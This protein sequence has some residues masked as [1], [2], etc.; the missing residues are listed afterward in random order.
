MRIW[1]AFSFLSLFLAGFASAQPKDESVV[2]EGFGVPD[3]SLEQPDL[4]QPLPEIGPAAPK[5]L[6]KFRKVRELTGPADDPIRMPT[7]VAVGKD[8]QVY[9]VDSGNNRIVVFSAEG[10]YLFSFGSVG[11]GDGQ[12]IAP[13]GIALASDGSVLVADRGNNRVQIFDGGGHFLKSLATRVGNQPVPP[14]DVVLG[15][16]ER[17]LYVTVS[18]P[19]H[20]VLVYDDKGKVHSVLGKPGNNLGDFRYPATLAVGPHD[21]LYVVDVFNSRVQVFNFKGK[22]LATVGSWGITPGKLFRPKGVAVRKDGL[23]LVSDSYLG[24]VQVFDTD[25]RFKAVLG[26]QGGIAYFETPTGLAVDDGGHLYV[27]EMLAN[28]VSVLYLDL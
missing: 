8:G 16:Q 10:K 4:P 12:L 24:V 26:N 13:V 25:T 7:D 23:I 14:V 9:V 2:P 28:R 1:F 18:S 5:P 15:D 21:D 11:E 19:V 3:K 17:Y 20:R 22:V 6:K 27:S